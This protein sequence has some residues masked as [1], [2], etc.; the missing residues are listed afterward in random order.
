MRADDGRQGSVSA[1]PPSLARGPEKVHTSRANRAQ[2]IVFVPENHH[3]WVFTWQ[4]VASR[5]IRVDA[6]GAA[7]APG[8]TPPVDSQ[9][10]GRVGRKPVEA[11]ERLTTACLESR[12]NWTPYVPLDRLSR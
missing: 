4:A 6:V 7:P 1:E 10:P 2:G 5:F 3:D 9:M 12:Q 11:A 8:L